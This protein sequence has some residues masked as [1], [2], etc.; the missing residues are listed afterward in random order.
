MLNALE[1]IKAVVAE[2]HQR[3]AIK[4]LIERMEREPNV[5]ADIG[6]NLQEFRAAQWEDHRRNGAMRAFLRSQPPSLHSQCREPD[7]SYLATR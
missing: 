2:S 3:S 6:L 1:F 7:N 4:A 5:L